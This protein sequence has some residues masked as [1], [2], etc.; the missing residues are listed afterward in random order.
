[1][2]YIF[3]AMVFIALFQIANAQVVINEIAWMG[4]NN[5]GTTNQNANDEWIELHNS[6]TENVDLSGWFLN[7]DDGSPSIIL[8]GVINVGE[9]FLLERSDDNSVSSVSADLIYTGVLSNS[10]EI[11]RI[12]DEEG[13]IIDIVDGTEYWQNIG[14]NNETKETAQR[15]QGSWITA[16]STPKALNINSQSSDSENSEQNEENSQS[17]NQNNLNTESQGSSFFVEPQ[18]F[19][20]AGKDRITTVGAD[21]LFEGKICGSTK[22]ELP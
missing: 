18:I 14:G 10:G 7:A 5:G 16:L 19:A 3:I 2:K 6:G 15:V 12:K 9:F 11:L 22:N 4:S 20:N 17:E 21:A 13:V 1:M 8:E